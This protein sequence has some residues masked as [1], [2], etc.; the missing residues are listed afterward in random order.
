[1]EEQPKIPGEVLYPRHPEMTDEPE[2]EED[3]E[4]LDESKSIIPL[5]F[6]LTGLGIVIL[7]EMCLFLYSLRHITETTFHKEL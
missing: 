6:P 4:E 2:E 3:I 1:M 7:L 5:V